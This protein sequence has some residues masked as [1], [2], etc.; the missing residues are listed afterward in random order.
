MTQNLPEKIIKDIAFFAEKHNIEKVILFG[1]RAKKTN[2]ERSDIDIAVSGGDFD[3]FYLDM[4]DNSNTLLTFD[5]V[6]A[7]E[8]IS[9]DLKE[10]ITRD[11]ITIYEKAR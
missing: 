6:N 2:T 7:D 11:G 8:N 9:G 4:K 5:I 10:E 1:S 3:A